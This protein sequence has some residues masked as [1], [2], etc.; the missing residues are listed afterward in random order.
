MYG[1]E[2][3]GQYLSMSFSIAL[4]RCDDLRTEESS[5]WTYNFKGLE[6]MTVVAKNSAAARAMQ[7]RWRSGS[8][9]SWEPTVWSTDEEQSEDRRNGTEVW[10]FKGLLWQ[11][12]SPNK[13]KSLD[14]SQTV[15]PMRTKYW[16]TLACRNPSQ[17]KP[18]NCQEWFKDKF[19]MEHVNTLGPGGLH[20]FIDYCIK[21]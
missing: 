3:N 14:P 19:K 17:S 6:S 8:F 2:K 18:N 16:N 1:R 11:H 21:R 7:A 20:I 5:F 13:A 15:P 4:I 12:T 9:S 10:N